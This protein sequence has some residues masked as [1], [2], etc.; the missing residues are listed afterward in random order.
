MT[1]GSPALTKANR[2]AETDDSAKLEFIATQAGQNEPAEE[3]TTTPWCPDRAKSK[4]QT[5][6][7]WITLRAR[8]AIKHT[9]VVHRRQP[10]IRVP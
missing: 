8:M 1:P 6:E 9:N 5:W 7:L 4:E 3:G 2:A 10:I